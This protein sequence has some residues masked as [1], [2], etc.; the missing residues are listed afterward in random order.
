MKYL[1]QLGKKSKAATLPSKVVVNREKRHWDAIPDF[2][3]SKKVK[4]TTDSKGK[5]TMWPKAFMLESSVVVKKLLE[6]VIPPFDR[7]ET[8]KLDLNRAISRI[9]F[10]I[11]Q[12]ITYPFLKVGLVYF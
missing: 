1:A 3:S 8:G 10:R 7:E 4:T 2:S 6:G 5:E 12:I 11:G 9:F